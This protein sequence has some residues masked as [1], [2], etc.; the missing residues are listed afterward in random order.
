[1]TVILRNPD[2]LKAVIR[3]NPFVG[4]RG[5]DEKGLY[6]TFLQEQP[7]PVLAKALRPL[8]AKTKDEYEIVGT[9]IYLHC[10]KGYG[11][12]LLNNSF[13]E[14]FLKVRATTR[15]WNTVN[16]LSS[17]ANEAPYART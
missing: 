9:A 15:N 7:S 3:K 2:E 6:V 16:I 10:R 14:K 11:T 5:V 12:S 17:M 13:F 4:R 1:M 8:T